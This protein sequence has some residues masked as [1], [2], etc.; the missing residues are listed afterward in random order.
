MLL[1]IKSI[2]QAVDMHVQRPFVAFKIMPPYIFDQ[3]FSGEGLAWGAP[4]LIEKLEFLARQAELFI[5]CCDLIRIVI[6]QQLAKLNLI[7]YRN[8]IAP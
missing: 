8:L 2:T 5:T 1:L 3:L 7:G 4:K 6:Q